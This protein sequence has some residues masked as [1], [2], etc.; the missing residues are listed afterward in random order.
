MEILEVDDIK[1]KEEGR[2]KRRENDVEKKEVD[3]ET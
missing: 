1:K 3:G 2:A